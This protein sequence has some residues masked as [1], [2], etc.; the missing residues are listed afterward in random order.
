VTRRRKGEL[1]ERAAQGSF[2]HWVAI[3]AERC[4][5][6]NYETH[7]RFCRENCLRLSNHGN[8]VRYDVEWW[9]VLHFGSKEDADAFMKEFGGEP[10]DSRDIGKGAHWSKWH[11]GRTAAKKWPREPNVGAVAI[12]DIPDIG[13]LAAALRRSRM[14]PICNIGLRTRRQ[15]RFTPIV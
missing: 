14:R 4:T 11:K 7:R 6:A 10:V 3:Q 13:L 15:L 12:G 8:T 1:I 9:C 5:G 2:P